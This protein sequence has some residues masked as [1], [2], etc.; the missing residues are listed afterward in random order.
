MKEFGDFLCKLGLTGLVLG[1][2]SFVV[3]LAILGF[4]KDSVTPA[5]PFLSV[6]P[7]GDLAIV[8]GVAGAAAFGAGLV[9][10]LI[11]DIWSR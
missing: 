10:E 9:A 8:L 3:H 2:A 1:A 7:F 6:S 11:G 5:T 4:N